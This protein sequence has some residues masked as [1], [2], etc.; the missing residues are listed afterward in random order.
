MKTLFAKRTGAGFLMLFIVLLSA[1]M[2][3]IDRVWQPTSLNSRALAS[4]KAFLS[5]LRQN[6]LAVT[7]PIYYL[8][9]APYSFAGSVSDGLLN[10]TELLAAKQQLETKLLT[11][12]KELQK[13]QFLRAE[14]R[15]LRQLLDST[16][17]LSEQELIAEIIGQPP[18]LNSHQIIIDKGMDDGVS[19]GDAVIDAQGLIGQVIEAAAYTSRVM[20]IVDRDHA[21]PARINRT[22]ARLIVGGTGDP[23]LLVLE[24]VPVSTDLVVGDLI[25]TSGFGGRFPV[26]YPVGRVV[27]V[28]N[29]AELAYW[30]ATVRPLAALRRAGYILVLTRSEAAKENSAQ[31]ADDASADQEAL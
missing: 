19:N 26:G 6:T 20:L 18:S 14:N 4:A 30:Q 21:V 2:I 13:V 9:E 5:G 10:R 27:S 12:S 11:M 7:Y 24:N 31:A 17:R 1:T 28:S 15:R 29:E 8:A 22:G 23:E 25:E 3:Y 16:E